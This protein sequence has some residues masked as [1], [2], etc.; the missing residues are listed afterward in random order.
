MPTR[1]VFMQLTI[2]LVSFNT[3]DLL[4]RCLASIFKHTRGIRFEV[5]VV[6]NASGDGSAEMVKQD[7]PRVKLIRNKTN[8][9]YTGANNQA[10]KLAKGKYFL[11]LNSDTHLVN[12]SLKVLTDYLGKNPDVA[13]VEPCQLNESGRPLP[14]AS[15]HNRWW[16]D[17]VGLT[18]LHRLFKPKALGWFHLQGISRRREFTSEVISDGAMMVRT[19]ILKQLGGYDTQL[20]LYYTEN[21]LC[22]RL[23]GLSLKTVHLGKAIIKHRVSASTD[24]AGWQTISGILATDARQYYLKYHSRLRAELLFLALKLNNWLILGRE[25]WGWLS[26]VILATVLRFYQLPAT[27][28][29]IGDQGRD[30]LAAR[31]MVQTGVWP[32]LGIPSSIPWL[33]Q[34]P[35]FIWLTAAMLKLGQFNP[36]TPAILTAILGVLS[37]YWLYRLSRNWWTGLILATSPLAIIH[38]RLPYHLS[39]IPLV[40]LGLMWAFSASSIPG[41]IF[42]SS[43]LLQFELSNLP[44]IFLVLFWFRR[45]WRELFKWA[46]LGLVPFAPKLIYDFTH[47]FSQ[48]LGLAA[49]TGYRLIHVN[50]YGNASAAIFDY[51]TKYIAPGY[52]YLAGM[53][54]LIL[55]VQLIKAPRWLSLMIIFLGLGFYIHGAPSEGYFLVLFPLWAMLFQP[56]HRLVK[57]G[58][59][60]LALFNIYNLTQH[61]FFPYGPS[62]PERL[63]LVDQLPASFKLV[64]FSGNPGWASYLDNYRYLLWW[65]GKDYQAELGQ[66]YSIYDGDSAAFSQPL[67]TTV[68]HLDKQKLIRYDY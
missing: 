49:W 17:L 54:G 45:R 39:P 27:M 12:N 53:I 42:F 61:N 16:L 46:P 65:R 59:I 11:I 35:I 29:F 52:P 68:F 64:N 32:L 60:G 9:W 14:T 34:G 57:F 21:D 36:V 31:D 19:R 6:D 8:K 2:S 25:H 23:Q 55:L 40:A 41:A 58:V 63:A 30:Y 44:L 62:L 48:T 26:L 4:R 7:F 18:G 37:V 56:R 20:K 28:T 24:K 13:A 5:I 15:R 66:P 43:L 10:L 3:R 50:Q 67:G 33:H 22:R 38:S 1:F 47:G 51:W